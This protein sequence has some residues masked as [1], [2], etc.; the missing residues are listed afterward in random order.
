MKTIKSGF[1]VTILL[2]STT[3]LT[4]CWD[5]R[6]INELAIVAGIAV[7]KSDDGNKYV[8]TAEI[9][10]LKGAGKENKIQSK[11]VQAEGKSFSDAVRNAIRIC[12]KH[13]YWSHS[14]I[15]IISQDV[16]KEGIMPIV[17]VYHRVRETRLPSHILISKEKTAK[18]LLS[19]ESIST[20]IRTVEMKK[21]IVSEKDFLGK[22]PHVDVRTLINML[23]SEGQAP[24]LSAIG[25][26]NNEGTYTS[27]LSGAAIFRGDKFVGFID[28]EETKFLLFIEDQIKDTMLTLHENI[29]SKY[30]GTTIEIHKNKTKVKAVKL[31]GKLSINIEINSEASLNELSVTENL[32]DNKGHRKLEKEAELTLK[33]NIE[34]VIKKV[35]E[36]YDLDIFGFGAT[37]KRDMPSEWKTISSKWNKEFKGLDVKVKTNIEIKESGISSKPI[38]VD[39]KK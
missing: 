10:D 5:Y 19:Q 15:V 7:D 27:E 28:G 38:K 14:D 4:G 8:L 6:E 16:A 37:V 35:Q 11:K 36:E 22:S 17:D 21:M 30:N 12:G 24:I 39:Y 1:L 3:A 20:E 29:D 33:A 23:G 2:L 31:N 13:L 25:I 34:H 26:V 32:L 9:V 18:E